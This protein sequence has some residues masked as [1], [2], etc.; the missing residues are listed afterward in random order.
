MVIDKTGAYFRRDGLGGSFICGL[1]PFP[2]DEPETS[3]LD[4]DY[5]FFDKSLWPIIANRV[6]AFNCLKVSSNFIP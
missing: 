1:S 3:N 5:N 2:E 6:P 4:V